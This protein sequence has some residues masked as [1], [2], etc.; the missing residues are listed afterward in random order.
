MNHF[1][2]CKIIYQN[3]KQN[4]QSRTEVLKEFNSI[5][6]VMILEISSN[7]NL[8]CENEFSVSQ[9][10]MSCSVQ[11]FSLSFFLIIP[12][13]LVIGQWMDSSLWSAHLKG[14]L[15]PSIFIVVLPIRLSEI[16][17]IIYKKQ[18]ETVTTDIIIYA[19]SIEF[20]WRGEWFRKLFRFAR[21]MPFKST[22]QSHSISMSNTMFFL[23]R[24]KNDINR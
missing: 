9:S 19:K 18:N 20:Y 3:Y 4:L 14:L 11:Q 21:N 2:L 24:T 7:S 16:G 8:N 13:L 12:Q 15:Y 23:S 10:L 22:H 1:L 17:R 6:A 5:S